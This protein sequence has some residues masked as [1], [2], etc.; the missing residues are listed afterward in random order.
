MSDFD[1]PLLADGSLDYVPGNEYH[2]SVESL[3]DADGLVISHKVDGENL[4]SALLEHG[5]ATFGAEISSPST[6]FRQILT[7]APSHTRTATQE[8]TW[9]EGDVCRPVYVRPL[10][11]FNAKDSREIVLKKH[12]GVHEFWLGSMARL[13][14]ATILAKSEFFVT[15]GIHSILTLTA[16][17]EIEDGA[18]RV[19]PNTKEDFKFDVEMNPNLIEAIRNPGEHTELRDAVLTAALVSGFYVL[20]QDFNQ[21]EDSENDWTKYPVL[22]RLNKMLK[23]KG[24][25]T[26][27]DDQFYPDEAASTLRPLRLS[28][29]VDDD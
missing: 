4:V 25:S 23:D 16:N 17:E 8:V 19:L 10:V 14:P 26:W 11:L 20:Q 6:T 28:K 13:Q 12:H 18:F 27:D 2:T 22:R 21:D 5:S 9:Q 15:S 24:I 29:V 3:P 7:A 1:V